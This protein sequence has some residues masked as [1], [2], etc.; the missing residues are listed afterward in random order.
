MEANLF[1]QKSCFKINMN[2]PC[3][4]LRL[5]V[6]QN[7]LWTKTWKLLELESGLSL[8]VKFCLKLK[9]NL[10]PHDRPILLY[11]QFYSLNICVLEDVLV[12]QEV[13]VVLPDPVLQL[14]AECDWSLRRLPLLHHHC[15][16]LP[17]AALS[18]SL[19]TSAHSSLVEQHVRAVCLFK[20]QV[21]ELVRYWVVRFTLQKN[22]S[23]WER[24]LLN[25][26]MKTFDLTI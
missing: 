19:S 11:K 22:T 1:Y 3:Y 5:K 14:L 13:H 26:L 12:P 10:Q 24:V 16:L 4:Y 2:E 7:A 21:H 9:L 18:A 17:A 15:R 23:K 8:D 6:P 25:R 20:A